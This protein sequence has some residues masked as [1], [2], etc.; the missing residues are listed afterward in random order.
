MQGYAVVLGLAAAACLYLAAPNQVWLAPG[1]AAHARLQALGSRMLCRLA[2]GLIMA[3]FLVWNALFGW[4]IAL[5]A[6][7]I[8]L[9]TG[10]SL[11]P[12]IGT[13]ADVRR[14]RSARGKEAQ[15]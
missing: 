15:A 11:W 8:T 14:R 13:Y 3:S 1:S 12:F 4:G 6:T 7:L 9:T 5:V 10:L 2:L